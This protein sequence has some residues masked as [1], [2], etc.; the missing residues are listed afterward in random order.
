VTAQKTQLVLFSEDAVEVCALQQKF[1]AGSNITVVKGNGP[2]VTKRYNL[3]ALWVSPMQAS[4]FGVSTPL[5]KHIG[6]VFPMP[7]EN[8]EKGLPRFLVTGAAMAPDDPET[9]EF[10][11]R[12]CTRA[13]TDAVAK[14]NQTH[15][16]VLR[17]IGSIPHN[18]CLDTPQAM[19]A[20]E[21]LLQAFDSHDADAQSH[22][23][24][25]VA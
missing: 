20:V 9:P 14:Y 13:L 1:V 17:R 7:K 23:I 6:H 12:L 25:Q 24:E 10:A 8:R 19:I 5:T 21:T 22:P 15:H 2:D 4:Y 11:A 16:G 18:L 3:D